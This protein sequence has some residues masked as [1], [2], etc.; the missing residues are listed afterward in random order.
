MGSYYFFFENFLQ[1]K[2]AYKFKEYIK[3]RI[4]DLMQLK[5]HPTIPCKGHTKITKSN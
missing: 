4:V 2:Y 3:S 1:Q 5:H